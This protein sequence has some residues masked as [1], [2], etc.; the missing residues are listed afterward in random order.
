[1]N[2]SKV[3][4]LGLDRIGLPTAICLVQAGLNILGVDT[5]GSRL[6]D[7]SE[8]RVDPQ[9]PGLAEAIGKSLTSG[10]LTLSTKPQP[11]DVFLLTL[12]APLAEGNTCDL[13]C[14]EQASTQSQDYSPPAI[15]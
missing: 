9:E 14:I 6:K 8:C 12:P 3:V 15:S 5:D 13:S 11:G 7:I 2:V 1:M 4:L 10:R